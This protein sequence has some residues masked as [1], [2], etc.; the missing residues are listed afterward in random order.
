MVD[1]GQ[2]LAKFRMH[3]EETVNILK[4][5]AKLLHTY[6]SRRPTDRDG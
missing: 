5:D 4:P 2:L 1:R 6:G 3:A